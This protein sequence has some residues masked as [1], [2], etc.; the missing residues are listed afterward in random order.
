MQFTARAFIEMKGLGHAA[1]AF[2]LIALATLAVITPLARS[3]D[4]APKDVIKQMADRMSA[5][6]KNTRMSLDEKRNELRSEVERHFDLDGM[7]QGSLGVHWHEMSQKEQAEFQTLFADVVRDTYLGRIQN[8]TA[9]QLEIID[10]DLTQTGHASVS[11]SLGGGGRPSLNMNFELKR[12]AGDWKISDYKFDT[13]SA[14]KN[15]SSHLKWLFEK[16][17]VDSLM[18]YLRKERARLDSELRASPPVST[19]AGK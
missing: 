3:A 17:G 9:E 12:I 16:K 13:E 5:T 1:F 8:Y 14:M 15:Y 19:E 11:G 7:A 6:L 2:L 10:Q 18:D 4:V